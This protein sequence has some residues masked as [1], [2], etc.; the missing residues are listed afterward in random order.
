MGNEL[1]L[2]GE[3]VFVGNIVMGYGRGSKVR[4]SRH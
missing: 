3:R 4:A 1:A 2:A